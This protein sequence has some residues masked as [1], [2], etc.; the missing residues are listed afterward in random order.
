M[1]ILYGVVG[2]GMGHATRS[3]VILD[4][5]Y[6]QHRILIVA[7]GKAHDYL[8]RF[9]SDIVEIEGLMETKKF[10]QTWITSFIIFL[11]L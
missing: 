9:Y 11:L 5:L 8:T 1:N 3:K 7:S 6:P 2:E 4:H 10:Y